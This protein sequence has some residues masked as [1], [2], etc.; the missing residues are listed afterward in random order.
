M[1]SCSRASTARISASTWSMY[2]PGAA[3]R[4]AMPSSNP[5]SCVSW[6][7][8]AAHVTLR[9]RWTEMIEVSLL[10]QQLHGPLHVCE[11][12]ALDHDHPRF[13]NER[14]PGRDL[15]LKI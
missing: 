9:G 8:R 6:S 3:S 5:S 13:R 12:D 7:P 14:P 1:S 11:C 4:S 10:E 2:A 15:F